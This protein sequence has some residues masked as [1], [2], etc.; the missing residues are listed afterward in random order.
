MRASNTNIWFGEF[1]YSGSVEKVKE[2]FINQFYLKTTMQGDSLFIKGL[3]QVKEYD[4]SVAN[5]SML[6]GAG[7]YMKF[8]NDIR[9]LTSSGHLSDFTFVV[10]GRELEVHK[11]ILSGKEKFFFNLYYSMN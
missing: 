10:Q 9:S 8:V 1:E 7:R 5:D 11:A 3:I 2:E 4:W 6:P